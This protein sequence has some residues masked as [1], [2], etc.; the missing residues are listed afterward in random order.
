MES[1]RPA[2]AEDIPRVVELAELMRAELGSMRGGA[3]WL[4]REAWAEPLD[5]AYGALLVR[6]DALLLVGAIDDAVIAFAAVALEELRSGA[7]LGVITDLFVEPE[8][9]EVGVGEVLVNALVEHCR[10]AGCLGVDA[11]ALPGHRAA[12]NF[13]E[14]HGFTARALTMH[15]RLT[16]PPAEQ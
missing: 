15:R 4:E 2:S 12:K 11:A 10:A 9:R 14:T 16:A 1:C 5:D 6:D 13:F 8:A 3:L 7:R